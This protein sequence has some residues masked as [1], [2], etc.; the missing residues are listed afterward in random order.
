[1]LRFLL[2]ASPSRPLNMHGMFTLPH[3]SHER[4]AK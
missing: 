1:M 2:L 4:S 3:L